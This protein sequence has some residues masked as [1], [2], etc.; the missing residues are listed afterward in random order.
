MASGLAFPSIFGPPSP[1]ELFAQDK[2]KF[3]VD[4]A[5]ATPTQHHLEFPVGDAEPENVETIWTFEKS[6]DSGSPSRRPSVA[7]GQ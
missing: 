2:L 4:T 5:V 3:L 7:T 1:Q 6:G